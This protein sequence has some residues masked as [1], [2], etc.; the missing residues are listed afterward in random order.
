MVSVGVSFWG[1]FNFTLVKFLYF[2]GVFNKTLI[3][4][5]LVG[6]HGINFNYHADTVTKRSCV[7]LH[8]HNKARSLKV[9]THDR[10]SSLN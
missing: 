7:E 9:S 4:L 8:V 6:Y 2:W 10:T 5:V 3:S 1:V